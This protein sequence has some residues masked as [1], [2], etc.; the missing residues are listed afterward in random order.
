MALNRIKGL[1]LLSMSA[2]TDQRN[3]W[4]APVLVGYQLFFLFVCKK[5]AEPSTSTLSLF[6]LVCRR[7]AF[8][9]VLSD[10]S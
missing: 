4:L 9:L 6:P 8:F 2:Y 10:I 1:R 7:N 5:N 3:S